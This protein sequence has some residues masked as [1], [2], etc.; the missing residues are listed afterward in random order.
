MNRMLHGFLGEVFCM[1]ALRLLR[2]LPSVSID[3]VFADAMYGTGRNCRYEWGTDPA[4]GDPVKHWQYHQPIYEECLRVLKPGG[5]LAW[6]QG[7]TDN[8][9]PWYRFTRPARKDCIT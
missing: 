5:I 9:K 4:R 3:G 2:A 7:L 6:G 8:A 1:D